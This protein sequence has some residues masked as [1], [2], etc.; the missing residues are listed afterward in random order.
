M[1]ATV[2]LLVSSVAAADPDSVDGIVRNSATQ[3]PV[4]HALVRLVCESGPG[5]VETTGG[6]GAFHFQ[7]V[8]PGEYRVSVERS[9]FTAR[10]LDIL[11]VT[12]GQPTRDL[13]LTAVPLAVLRGK[14]VDAE[15]EPVPNAQVTA[16]RATWVRGKRS[17][18][19]T[20]WTEAD[21]R[22]EFRLAK[23]DPGRYRLF[24]SPPQGNP[25]RFVISEGPGTPESRLAPAYYPSSQDLDAAAPLDLAAG[26][27]LGGFELKL[28]TRPSFH[29]RG[30]AETTPDARGPFPAIVTAVKIDNSRW[31]DWFESTGQLDKDGSFDLGGVLPGSYQIYVGRFGRAAT[32][33]IG[34]KVTSRDV[35]GIALGRLQPAQIQVRCIYNGDRPAESGTPAFQLRRIGRRYAGGVI[36][37]DEMAFAY[38][39]QSDGSL[40]F[41]NVPSGVYEP[42][43]APG[44]R[45]YVE[46]IIYN[47]QPL[48]DGAIDVAGGS[49]GALEVRL[50]AATAGVGG[51]LKE[52]RSAVAV[53]VAE[54]ASLGNPAVHQA[55]VSSDGRFSL[56]N[57]PPGRYLV[58]AVPHGESWPWDNAGFVKLLSGDATAVDLTGT[59]SAQVE[60]ALIP[61]E[62]LRRAEEQ[63]P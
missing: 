38:M 24:A 12:A 59:A 41:A 27:E 17:W 4:A 54:N 55:P 22:G 36:A 58:F 34:V 43:L 31:T 49:E 14:V 50:A 9:G 40:R 42:L 44:A 53:V 61:E 3:G 33:S 52:P 15:G 60:I 13:T 8:E 35:N 62:T 6:D 57:L 47:G 39:H 2:L 5:Y 23:L 46:S 21:E 63:I 26:Q 11:H 20:G 10:E 19:S 32:E 37:D 48:T 18:Q 29:I 51:K 56:T 30:R 45:Q 16:I 1:A 25:L 28:P 7:K